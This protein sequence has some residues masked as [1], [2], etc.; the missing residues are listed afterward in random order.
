MPA[1]F[2]A[3]RICAGKV[4]ISSKELPEAK[5]DRICL[6]AAG[7]VPARSDSGAG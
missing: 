1:R 2:I 5:E 4:N 7:S 6:R 3:C